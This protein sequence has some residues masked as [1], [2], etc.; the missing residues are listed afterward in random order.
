MI[1]RSQVKYRILVLISSYYPDYWSKVLHFLFTL[2]KNNKSLHLKNDSKQRFLKTFLIPTGKI[3]LFFF[4]NRTTYDA[5]NKIFRFQHITIE[6]FNKLLPTKLRFCILKNLPSNS[7]L[8]C[9]LNKTVIIFV[10]ICL[11]YNNNYQI[12]HL[13]LNFRV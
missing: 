5:G 3:L 6:N 2:K 11:Y 1:N 7:N 10:Q 8:K 4:L 9:I 13:M 12:Y